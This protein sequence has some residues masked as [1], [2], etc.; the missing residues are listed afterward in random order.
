MPE[1]KTFTREE[2]AKHSSENDC[3]I[4]ID[5]AVYDVT[6]FADMHPGGAK[7]L[8]EYGGKDAT[9]KAFD[10]VNLTSRKTERDISD[11]FYGLHRQEVLIKY[12]P[13]LKIGVIANEKPQYKLPVPG[14][15]S[16]VPYAEPS[17]WMGYKSPY[18]K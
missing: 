6:K 2:V 8:L 14:E 5:S 18:L 1:L 16:K 7:L 4:I 17:Y 13:R 9:G 11:D 10:W 3:W 12:A 15:L